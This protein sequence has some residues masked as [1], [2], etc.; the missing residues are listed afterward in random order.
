MVIGYPASPAKSSSQTALPYS[1]YLRDPTTHKYFSVFGNVPT[2]RR[3][4]GGSVISLSRGGKS[5]FRRF[6]IF[7]YIIVSNINTH[8][9]TVY[10]RI[11]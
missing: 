9:T 4:F 6:V 7:I 10:V 3:D 1:L 11:V 5:F 8:L 2:V